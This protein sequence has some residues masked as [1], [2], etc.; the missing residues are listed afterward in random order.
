[1]TCLVNLEPDYFDA[2]ICAQFTDWISYTDTE[3]VSTYTRYHQRSPKEFLSSSHAVFSTCHDA[4]DTYR[5][6]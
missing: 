5:P 6:F 2:R 4:E 3:E 1:M